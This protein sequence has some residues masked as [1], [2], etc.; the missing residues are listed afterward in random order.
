M[1]IKKF[2]I[3]TKPEKYSKLGDILFDVTIL[4]LQNQFR[5]GLDSKDIVG[6]FSEQEEAEDLAIELLFELEMDIEDG[7]ILD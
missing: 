2:F 6:V 1:E 4:G 5:G 7:Y 3:V